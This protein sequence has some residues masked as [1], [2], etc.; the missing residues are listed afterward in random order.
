VITGSAGRAETADVEHE[1]AA[2][3]VAE[4][5][6]VAGDRPASTASTSREGRQRGHHIA[7]HLGTG[8]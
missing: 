7:A 5:H 6:F 4:R 3:N 2:A 8:K 1:A